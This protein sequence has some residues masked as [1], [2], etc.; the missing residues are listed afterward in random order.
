MDG[1]ELLSQKLFILPLVVV[2]MIESLGALQTFLR[3]LKK[4]FWVVRLQTTK[5]K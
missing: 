2:E 5:S 4:L 3:F 1:K